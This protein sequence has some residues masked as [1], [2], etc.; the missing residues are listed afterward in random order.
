MMTQTRLDS[1][2]FIRL[3]WPAFKLSNYLYMTKLPSRGMTLRLYTH[4]KPESWNSRP[5]NPSTLNPFELANEPVCD[6]NP[7]LRRPFSGCGFRIQGLGFWCSTCRFRDPY[8]SRSPNLSA[9]MTLRLPYSPPTVPS[10]LQINPLRSRFG[11]GS[12]RL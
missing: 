9:R 1:S 11:R 8:Q 6:L 4:D 2:F 10:H 5:L 7:N 3:G 12:S